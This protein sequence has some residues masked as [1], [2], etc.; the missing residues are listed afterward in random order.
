MVFAWGELLLPPLN[1][2]RRKSQLTLC[3]D[4]YSHR[5]GYKVEFLCIFPVCNVMGPNQNH[6]SWWVTLLG[7]R[8]ILDPTSESTAVWEVK[9]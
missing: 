9:G 5:K 3:A 1:G 2:L 8:M 6:T 4:Y 7:P